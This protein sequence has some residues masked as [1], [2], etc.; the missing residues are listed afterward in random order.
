MP[1]GPPCSSLRVR[2]EPSRSSRGRCARNATGPIRVPDGRRLQERSAERHVVS[3]IVANGVCRCNH[4]DFMQRTH[5]PWHIVAVTCLALALFT[6]SAAAQSRASS[7][8]SSPGQSGATLPL[9]SPAPPPAAPAPTPAPA[10]GTP[11]PQVPSVAPLSPAVPPVI[12]S[13]GGAP[14][15]GSGSLALSPGSPSESVPS[16]PGGGG[17]TLSDCMGFWEPATHMSKSE[18]KAACQRTLSRIQ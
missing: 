8:R 15:Q 2:P 4:E 17:K 11:A 7:G 12:S 5:V 18:W 10:L 14:K 1:G 9:P 13:S 3:H 6:D 16:A